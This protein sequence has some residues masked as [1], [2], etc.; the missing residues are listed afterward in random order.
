LLLLKERTIKRIGGRIIEKF[1]A[2]EN[3]NSATFLNTDDTAIDTWRWK[4]RNDTVTAIVDSV[5]MG[6]MA[7]VH[8]RFNPSVMIGDVNDDGWV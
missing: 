2:I 6:S 8:L 5:V 4:R 7:R 1:K 3:L